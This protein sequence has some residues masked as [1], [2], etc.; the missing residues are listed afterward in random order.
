MVSVH[1]DQSKCPRHDCAANPLGAIPSGCAKH[2][3]NIVHLA[4]SSSLT[5]PLA[6]SVFFFAAS[7]PALNWPTTHCQPSLT[8]SPSLAKIVSAGVVVPYLKYV[9]CLRA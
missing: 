1:I 8:P 2:K 5:F 6:S 7:E 4:Y 9:Y 3:A